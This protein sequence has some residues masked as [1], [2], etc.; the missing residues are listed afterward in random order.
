METPLKIAITNYKEGISLFDPHEDLSEYS[1]GR[2]DAYKRV[3][4][5]LESLLP[6]EKQ[7]I[8]SSYN[9]GYD[10]GISSDDKYTDAEDY[11]TQTFNK[12]S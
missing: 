5:Y 7:Q 11:F 10:E 3:I 1:R 2:I 4:G 6:Y 8:H 9:A 12:Q